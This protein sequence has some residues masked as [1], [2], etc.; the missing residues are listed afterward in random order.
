MPNTDISCISY[1]FASISKCLKKVVNFC[2]EPAPEDD[3]V[4]SGVKVGHPIIVIF[5]N[6]SEV[7]DR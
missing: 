6:I 3:V 2:I 5:K 1:I 4:T 7:L